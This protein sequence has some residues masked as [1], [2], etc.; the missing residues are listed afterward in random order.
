MPHRRFRLH[1]ATFSCPATPDDD[2]AAM[3][4]RRHPLRR[5]ARRRCFAAVIRCRHLRYQP[6]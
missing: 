3:P 5:P 2:H 6:P 1:I 4:E